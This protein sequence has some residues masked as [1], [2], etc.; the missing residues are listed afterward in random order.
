MAKY[1]ITGA[2]GQLGQCFRAIAHEFSLDELIF[3]NQNEVDITSTNS[4]K[5]F[6]SNNPFEG[7]INCAAYTFVEKAEKEEQK[8][9]HINA[10]GVKNIGSFAK[11]N[12]LFVVHFSTDH[13]FDGNNSKP[14]NEE[15]RKNPI[16]KYGK[17]KFK[18][19]VLLKKIKC[20]H[21][22]FRIA[23][24]FS[25]FGNNFVKTIFKL[26]E[27]E[28]QI[29]VVNDQYGRP[30][31]GIEL[32]RVILKNISKSNFFNYDSYNYG[33]S[34]IITWNEFASKILEFKNNSLNII[35]C[36]SS[37]YHSEVKRPRYGVLDTTRIESH[38]SLKIL[39][40]ELA[41]KDCVNRIQR[42]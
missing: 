2:D 16:N 39:N 36:L 14:Y 35:P 18:G 5:K 31:Y 38:F 7:I 17:S 37:E 26:S 29:K 21:T 34:G 8:A 13:V 32:A 30:T 41:L 4:L 6:Y 10:H 33:Q 23:W 27:T 19:E 9:N 28:K 24:L 12:S 25:P 42:L 40:W 20:T 22:T 11:E 3:V 15:D 1:L